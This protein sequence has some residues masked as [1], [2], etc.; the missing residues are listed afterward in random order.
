MACEL[1][2]IKLCLKFKRK[3]QLGLGERF[4]TL[5]L[6]TPPSP[7]AHR[8]DWF[9]IPSSLS[10]LVWKT[11]PTAPLRITSWEGHGHVCPSQA[12][13][14]EAK[15]TDAEPQGLRGPRACVARSL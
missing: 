15:A 1:Y 5:F 2:F 10:F 6:P 3:E 8:Q 14:E 4:P 9:F 11:R 12:L 7:L 13:R